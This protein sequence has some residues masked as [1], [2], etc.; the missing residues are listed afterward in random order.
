MYTCL[1]VREQISKSIPRRTYCELWVR[2]FGWELEGDGADTGNTTSARHCFTSTSENILQSWAA[3]HL[4]CRVR[5]DPTSSQ[6]GVY[7]FRQL[8]WH[9]PSAQGQGCNDHRNDPSGPR[10]GSNFFSRYTANI[11]K[12]EAGQN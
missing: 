10:A 8:A 1:Q 11:L 5:Y 3:I 6:E 2:F 12:M 7:Q 4:H 9:S